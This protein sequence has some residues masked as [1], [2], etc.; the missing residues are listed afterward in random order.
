[1]GGFAG[2]YV[3]VI[4][5]LD[6]ELF[7]NLLFVSEIERPSSIRMFP[8]H[9]LHTKKT[10]CCLFTDIH[11]LTVCWRLTG[12]NTLLCQNKST[13]AKSEPFKIYICLFF[14]QAKLFHLIQRPLHRFTGP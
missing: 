12:N 3:S 8:G 7:I 5:R 14:N 2:N 10:A 4:T 6:P 1:M 13:L 9:G 11:Q